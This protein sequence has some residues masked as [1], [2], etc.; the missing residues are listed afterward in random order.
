M[1]ENTSLNTTL[2]TKNVIWNL[3]DI[4]SGTDDPQLLSD[5]SWCLEEA[6]KVHAEYYDRVSS[7]NAESL[8]DLVLRLEKIDSTLTRL[9]TFS[10]L[11][12]TTRLDNAEAAGPSSLKLSSLP[13]LHAKI[14]AAP[15]DRK[16][17][18]ASA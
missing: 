9:G 15:A 1:T 16:G 4:Y 14:S 3:T 12:F 5:M 11:N 2:G 6:G 10:F 17:R 8:L 7:L 13:R 18:T